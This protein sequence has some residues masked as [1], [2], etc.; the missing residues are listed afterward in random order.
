MRAVSAVVASALLGSCAPNPPL[1][2]Q[3]RTLGELRIVTQNAPT[4]FYYGAT[5]RHGIE[6]ELARAFADHLG[7]RLKLTT[8][9]RPGQ[10]FPA[11]TERRAHIAAAGLSP[12]ESGRQSVAFGPG[13][14]TVT[15]QVIYRMGEPRPD[16]LAEIV[17]GTLEVRAGSSHAE[18]LRET[19]GSLPRLAFAE[20]RSASAETLM[21]R[22]A[23]GTIDFAVVNSNAFELLR[24]YYPD[25]SVAFD[26]ASDGELA[27]ALPAGAPDLEEEVG[28]FF[29]NLRATG[30]LE[31]ILDK[32]YEATRGFDFV[33]SRAFVRHLQERFPEYQASFAAAERETGI[34]WRLL[35]AIA[36]QESHWDA[37]AVS[38]TGVKGLMM[39]TAKTAQIVGVDDRAD[40][41]ASILGGARYLKRVLGKFPERIPYEDRLMMAVAA[42]NV[43][44]GHVED[45][46]IITESLDA[47]K[48]NWEDVREH[49]PLLADERW[50]PHLKRGYAQGSVPARYVEN[51][52]H[53]YWLLERL[54]GTQMFSA[55]PGEPAAAGN[56]I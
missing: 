29:A 53:Y 37:D 47:D 51:I 9:E 14:Q 49:L 25:V 6:Y 52:R 32:Y 4:T 7:V 43:G 11:L 22:V 41:H 10:L 24:H 20:N 44:F 18:L 19:L 35:A 38:P 2:E 39:L 15:V 55:L 33:G 23:A 28:K 45:A 48:D 42:Y 17:G 34:D 30:E 1:L 50:Y 13:Y 36:Y 3:I 54:R 56:P 40:P 21:R 27:W 8:V 31:R 26:L 12:T 5:E 46:R 16:S